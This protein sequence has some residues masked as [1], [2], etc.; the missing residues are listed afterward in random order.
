[1]TGVHQSL[2]TERERGAG[3][4]GDSTCTVAYYTLKLITTNVQ[5][6]KILQ[7]TQ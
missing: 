3:Q 6:L 7:L 1:M 5:S 4:Y 2:E